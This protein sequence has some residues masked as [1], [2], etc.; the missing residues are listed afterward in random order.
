MIT[1]SYC[2]LEMDVQFVT[3]HNA[4]WRGYIQCLYVCL[5]SYAVEFPIRALLHGWLSI[6]WIESGCLL[7]CDDCQ[8][9]L[10]VDI[11][12]TVPILGSLYQ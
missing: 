2:Q 4:H 11:K 9:V 1:T 12:D 5:S 7:S 10:M 6:L 8:I 3:K